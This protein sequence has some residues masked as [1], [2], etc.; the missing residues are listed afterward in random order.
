V[1]NHMHRAMLL[2]VRGGYA[3]PPVRGLGAAPPNFFFSGSGPHFLG[4][5]YI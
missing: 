3:E 1:S 4:P 2:G 5:H